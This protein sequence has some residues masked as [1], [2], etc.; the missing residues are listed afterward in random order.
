MSQPGKP[1]EYSEYLQLERLL[2]SQALK[3]AEAG[4]PAHDEMLFV[5]VHQTYE[6]WFKQMLHELDSVMALFRA[7]SVDERSIGVALSRLLRVGEIQRV[8]IE[9]LRVL[10]TMTP[11][12]FLDFRDMLLPASGFESAQFRL[13]ELKLGLRREQRVPIE[14]L[15]QP[16]LEEQRRALQE[17]QAAA[18]LFELVERWL[19][20][21][22]FLEL[23]G[24]QFWRSYRQAVETMLAQDRRTLEQ[25]GVLTEKERTAQL[26]ELDAARASFEALFDETTH[27]RLISEGQRRLSHRATLAALLIHLYREQPI[28]HLPF[29]FLTALV[30]IDELLASWRYRHAQ[31][32]HR[33]IGAKIGTGGTSG[34]RYLLATI[35]KNKVWTDLY[36]LSTF[37]IARSA[38]PPLPPEVERRLGFHYPRD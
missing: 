14:R 20:R 22:P 1:V 8:L 12:D 26:Q 11:L 17:A 23:P 24:Y 27:R 5:I 36:N 31:M 3:S 35:E 13:I 34:H 15:S 32:V 19:E 16:P 2:G 25:S 18:S 7:D 4:R 33:M 30:E 6:L 9:Q 21:T 29:R 10:E 37:L 28:L 38:L